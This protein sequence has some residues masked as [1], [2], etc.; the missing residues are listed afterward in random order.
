M[1]A[2]F[3]GF[4][5]GVLGGLVRALAIFFKFYRL[6]RICGWGIFFMSVTLLA[7]GGLGGII[8]SD[9][10]WVFSLLGGY[11]AIDLLGSIS[12]SFSRKIEVE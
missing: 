1:E 7:A 5:F 8:F 10:G 3:S 6:N 4:L 9:V 11:A 12:K 2:V